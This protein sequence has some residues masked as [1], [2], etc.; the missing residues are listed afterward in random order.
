MDDI[1]S[2]LANNARFAAILALPSGEPDH[3]V[4]FGE[5][6]ERLYWF[7]KQTDFMKWEEKYHPKQPFLYVTFFRIIDSIGV[8]LANFA[9]YSPNITY[10][11]KS[12]MVRL[13]EDNRIDDAITMAHLF[14]QDVRNKMALGSVFTDVPSIA[15]DSVN[16][17]KIKEKEQTEA[18]KKSTPASVTPSKRKSDDG[19][20]K[21]PKVPKK[22]ASTVA[23]SPAVKKPAK[24][25]GFFVP[26]PGCD[27]KKMFSGVPTDDENSKIPCFNHH[28]IGL[29]CTH[30]RQCRY[31]HGTFVRFP[32]EMQEKILANML[33]H[34][35]AHINP[36]MKNS[37]KF[38]EIVGS[39][40]E[41]LWNPTNESGDP[42]TEGA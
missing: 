34:K 32:P 22:S 25:M 12:D 4:V 1:R 18:A 15:P 16:P 31:L 9:L 13:S 2:M 14:M 5:I 33:K 30:G 23:P 35:I 37:P 10:G 7:A 3:E 21:T 39:D 40:Y 11:L 41:S 36:L 28:A 19:E 42:A 26:G 29:E 38:K 24:E 17:S 27:Y 20:K 6:Y 8:S